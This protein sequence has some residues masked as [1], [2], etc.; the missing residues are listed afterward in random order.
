[1]STTRKSTR[2]VLEVRLH[3][4]G[5][6]GGVTCAKILATVWAQLG[7]SVQSF[8]DYAGER[9]GAPVR[10]YMRMSEGPIANRNKVYT[11]DHLLV[12]DPT[13]LGDEVVT[14]LAPGGTL[15]VN[16]PQSPEELALR[17]PG[18]RVATVDATA[19]ARRHGIGTKSVVIVNTTIAGAFVR[20]MDLP[21]GAL[22][23]A[24]RG[25]GFLSNLPAAREA[26]EQVR[27]GP[28]PDPAAVR[29][30]AAPA[31][32]AAVLPL[33]DHREGPPP[34]VHTGSWRTQTPRYVKN[35]APCNAI[36]PAGNDV[37]AFL[38]AAA[39]GDEAAAA[40]VLG[41]TTP[42][43]AVCGR[44]CDAPC[45]RNCNRLAH[46]GAVHVRAVERFV[47]D[48]TPVAAARA[49][50]CKDPRR[51]AIVGA[52]PCGLSA[53][54]TLA[55]LGHSAT[56]FERESELGGFLRS[57]VPAYRLPRDVLDREIDGVLR[58]SVEVRR[59]ASLGPD[60]VLELTRTFDAVILATGLGAARSDGTP[61]GVEPGAAF[62]HDVNA[63]IECRLAGR[64][65]VLGGSDL[66]L[67][68]ARAALRCGAAE[69]AIVHAGPSES[70]TSH[71]DDLED[72]VTEGVRFHFQRVAREFEGAGHV[73]GVV[74][75]EVAP[76]ADGAPAG[77]GRLATFAADTVLDATAFAPEVAA[78]PAG[79]TLVDGRFECG[80]DPLP[81][82]AAGDVVS[83]ARSVAL[84]VGDGRRVALRALSALG[85][86]VSVPAQPDRAR[87]VRPDAIRFDHFERVEP[88]SPAAS[89]RDGRLAAFAEV[90]AG[91]EDASE[92]QRCLSCG[93][94]TQCDTCLVYCPEGVIK[95]R[96]NGYVVDGADCKGCGIC[97]AECPRQAMEMSAS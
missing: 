53:A 19:I 91:L 66:A 43:A 23:D 26:W 80:G 90:R 40:A 85:L 86:T 87:A 6:Q 64:V 29:A 9:S 52:G 7:R 56:V 96:G 48:R 81:A 27:I 8:G 50:G 77:T 42:F 84:A 68:C 33:L 49:A 1:M 25:L 59:G 37:V 15:L 89:P 75:E 18:F 13:L 93:K 20:A 83:S 28:A 38:H 3:G 22:E 12:L 24:Y 67:D 74:V 17:F 70:L 71:A 2:D 57:E 46:D 39:H 65:V 62:L 72:A 58:L 31:A 35:L 79:W 4:R 5:G 69:A 45:E 14:G 34:P 32:R 47:A 54:Y 44:V 97:V 63:G 95:R 55:R 36:C 76:G 61:P 51:V 41:R 21:L 10:A 88:A 94:C 73:T 60:D 82:F 30:P 78:V 16:T 11:P 92:A